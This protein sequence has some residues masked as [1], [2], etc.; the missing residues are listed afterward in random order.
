[1]EEAA[2]NSAVKL[3]KDLNVDRGELQKE[4]LGNR[5]VPDDGRAMF[6]VKFGKGSIGK[7]LRKTQGHKT[8][9]KQTCGDPHLQRKKVWNFSHQQ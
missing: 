2:L 8:R 6:R 7:R 9:V 4:K 1:M 5:R 3:K